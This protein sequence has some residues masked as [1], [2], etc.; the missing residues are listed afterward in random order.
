MML[1]ILVNQ[2]M[3][4]HMNQMVLDAKTCLS[5]N[6]FASSERKD[7]QAQDSSIAYLVIADTGRL[8][9]HR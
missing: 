7:L 6:L 2:E 9:S 3:I 5:D 1:E 8:W 4:A